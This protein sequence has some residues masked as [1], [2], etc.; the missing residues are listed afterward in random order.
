MAANSGTTTEAKVLRSKV[1]QLEKQL[2]NER[3]RVRNLE[4]RVRQ[5]QGMSAD[6]EAKLQKVAGSVRY[7]IV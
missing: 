3:V 7:E 6:P 1:E 2:C 4:A 5:S